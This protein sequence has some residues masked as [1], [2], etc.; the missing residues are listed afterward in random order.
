[1][2]QATFSRHGSYKIDV[3]AAF[4]S[5]SGMSSTIYW[6]IV[7]IKTN[8]QGHAAWGNTGSSGFA[9]SSLGAHSDRDLWSNYNMQYNFQN[10]SNNGTFLI[11]EGT[12]QVQH[13]ADGNAEYFVSG[14]LD[15]HLLG[16]AR[17]GTGW[18][19]LPRIHTTTVPA[20]PSPIAVDN[21]TPDSLRFRFSGNNNGGTPVR[22]WQIHY[23]TNSKSGQHAAWSDGTSIITGLIPATKYYFWARGRND[24]GWGPFSEPISGSTAA[25]VRIKHGGTWKQAIPYVKFNGVWRLAQPHVKVN[26][27]WKKTI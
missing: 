23:G 8:N 20:A 27:V 7:V 11:Q 13:R 17:A 22:E 15:Y 2:G 6:R 24:V 26:G 21:A 14:Q 1:M 18:R 19:S 5:Q 12:F 25:G 4:I 16:S 3:D 10:G 9:E